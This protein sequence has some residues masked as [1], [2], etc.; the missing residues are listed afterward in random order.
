MLDLDAPN[1]QPGSGK[2]HSISPGADAKARALA[3]ETGAKWKC[4]RVGA[5]VDV[6]DCLARY[7]TAQ[8]ARPAHSPCLECSSIATH[9]RKIGGIPEQKP[10]EKK[11]PVAAKNPV[12]KPAQ[13]APQAPDANPF[14]GW[15]T[16]RPKDRYSHGR[17]SFAS[18]SRTAI[19]FSAKAKEVFGLGEI[20]TI[21]LYRNG[22]KI[23]LQLHADEGGAMK[24]TNE[25]MGRVGAKVAAT[26]LIRDMGLTTEKTKGRR[27]ELREVAPG[28][29]EIDTAKGVAK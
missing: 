11:M 29:L 2:T 15:A 4:S 14:S 16:Y 25:V 13:A 5:L 22:S 9:I 23:G 18:I 7:A 26:G 12:P 19:M 21:T 3:V 6:T 27:F 20:K 17:D 28:F 24:C 8:T 10:L 1:L